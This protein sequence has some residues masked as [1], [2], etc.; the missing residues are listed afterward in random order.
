[1]QK[2]Q[3]LVDD[4]WRDFFTQEFSKPYTESLRAFLKNELSQGKNIFPPKQLWFNA[5]LLTP[6]RGLNV[7][8]VGQDPYH[9]AGQ[10]HGLSFSVPKG[11]AR[12]PSLKNIIKEVEQCG[13]KFSG[14]HGNLE[15]W[16][17]Q[18][19]FLLNSVLTVQQ[20]N[21][22]SHAKKGWEI[23]TKAAVEYINTQ[24]ENVV[25]LAWGR[26]AHQVC[27]NI[28]TSRHLLIKTSHPS[29][30]GATKS[31]K[32]FCAFLGS[33]CFLTANQYLEKHQKVTVNW[34]VRD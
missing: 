34:S 30:L 10:A 8:I 33:Q 27:E 13:F 7:V 15:S 25:F 23:F 16:A 24:T 4:S 5:F 19:V 20:A 28:D 32:D 1:M 21:A 6:L 9:G 17:A 14:Q 11:I 31:G 3:E 12:P 2:V 29:P 26:Y 22:G 18:G